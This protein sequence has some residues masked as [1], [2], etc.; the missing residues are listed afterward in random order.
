MPELINPTNYSPL[1]WAV[2]GV[3]AAVFIVWLALIPKLTRK[4][5][6][7]T[8][9][10]LVVEKTPPKSLREVYFERIHALA[11]QLL[12]NSITE[13]DMH[14]ELSKIVR[15]YVGTVTG[16]ATRTMTYSDLLANPRTSPMAD[17]IAQCY[18]PAFSSEGSLEG[19]SPEEQGDPITVNN[20]LR[21]VEEL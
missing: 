13:R 12:E 8:Y 14:L 16:V 15:E 9:Q 20:A 1:W 19:W 21:V 6:E 18:H 10:E 11:D 5:A 2:F 3:L 4:R 17:V 7:R